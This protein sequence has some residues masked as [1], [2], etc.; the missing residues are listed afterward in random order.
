MTAARTARRRALE[1]SAAS[2]SVTR[3]VTKTGRSLPIGRTTRKN[4]A[5]K[6]PKARPLPFYLQCH[7]QRRDP[8]PLHPE[9]AT[10]TLP[11]GHLY[12]VIPMMGVLFAVGYGL[13]EARDRVE[14][15]VEGCGTWYA[16]DTLHAFEWKQAAER[17]GYKV[18]VY[19]NR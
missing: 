16:S 10:F 15:V 8:L 4:K 11:R 19:V 7:P 9:C 1:I 14:I 2:T 17:E 6:R 3:H 12:N 18:A 5:V 13:S